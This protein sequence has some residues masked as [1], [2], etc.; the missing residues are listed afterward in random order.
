MA[1]RCIQTIGMEFTD[2]KD[3]SR[4][5]RTGFMNVMVVSHNTQEFTERCFLR[6]ETLYKGQ[7]AWV[8]PMALSA[9]LGDSIAIFGELYSSTVNV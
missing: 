6:D 8:S 9:I 7:Q 1:R 4:T 3:T 2:D 5:I